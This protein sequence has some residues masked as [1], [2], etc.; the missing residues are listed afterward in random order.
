MKKT[1]LM[2]A[3]VAALGFTVQSCGINENASEETAT[4]E[5]ATPKSTAY[6]LEFATDGAMSVADFNTAMAD[7]DSM[8]NIVVEGFITEVC[9]EEG[10]WMRI[11][12]EGGEDIFVKFKDHSFLIPKDLMDNKVHISGMGKKT[13]VSVADLQHF[14]ADAGA[15][16]KEIAEITEP[17]DEMRIV[18]T[19]LV[20]YE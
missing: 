15:T 18:A 5:E 1:L 14:A 11:N 6:G 2:I 4:T 19:G 10:C 20:V 12:N 7:K 16:A 13:T 9:Q 17:K 3:A 8:D